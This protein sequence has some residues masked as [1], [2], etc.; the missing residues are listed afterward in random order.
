MIQ[1]YSQ[2]FLVIF[3]FIK[4]IER[5]YRN[6]TDSA[7]VSSVALVI[8]V[9]ETCNVYTWFSS[10]LEGNV[11]SLIF[12]LLFTFNMTVFY[13]GDNWK[14]IV[15]NTVVDPI[16]KMLVVT[17]AVASISAGVIRYIGN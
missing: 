9:L 8:S 14:K 3:R 13:I 15:S 5:G 7:R 16:G 6:Q 1:I 4:S 11:Y 17:Y 2:L 10:N 12:I